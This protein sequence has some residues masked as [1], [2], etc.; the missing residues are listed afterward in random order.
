MQ[1]AQTQHPH[2]LQ[3]RKILCSTVGNVSLYQKGK[4]ERE[5]EAILFAS[6]HF[7]DNLLCLLLLTHYSEKAYWETYIHICQM[8]ISV[9]DFFGHTVFHITVKLM[10]KMVCRH[11]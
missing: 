2:S 10:G 9:H 5:K 4:R 1:M 7:C 8:Y 3:V 6:I 11:S